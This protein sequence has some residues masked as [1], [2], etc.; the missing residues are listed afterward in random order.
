M[1]LQR[2]T[3]RPG[4]CTLQTV[5]RHAL[6]P[7]LGVLLV[8]SC[9]DGDSIDNDTA[10]DGGADDAQADATTDPELGVCGE[11]AEDCED[12]AS[13]RPF[14]LS[15]HGAA[16]L[17]ERRQMLVFG[18]TNA[19]AEACDFPAPD[20][21]AETW[22]FDDACGKWK[23]LEIEDGPS[24]RARHSMT[25]GNGLAWMFGGRWGKTGS[26]DGEYVVYAELWTFDPDSET[27]DELEPE[28]EAP[29]PRANSAMT[30]DSTRDV[31]WVWGGNIVVDGAFRSAND[32]WQY[33]PRG[34]RW[35]EAEADS[36]SPEARL[37]HSLVYDPRRDQ[38]VLYGGTDESFVPSEGV[39]GL[40]LESLRWS[41]LDRSGTSGPDLRYWQ[42]MVLDRTNDRL[43]MM[44]GHDN[45]DLGNRNDWW[46][47]EL[48]NGTWSLEGTGDRLNSSANG[49]CDFP[50]DFTAPDL[51][52]PER[53]HGHSMVWSESCGHTIVF[54]GKTDCGAT[55]DVW[56]LSDDG[57]FRRTS[58][59]EGEVCIRWREDPDDCSNLC[60]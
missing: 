6:P 57:W 8:A 33:D 48:E 32:L 43:V 24:P 27:W 21:H 20:Y 9:G 17:E 5:L 22:I 15:E 31:L 3:C 53:R 50:P 35:S 10:G 11:L 39:W 40:D 60:N 30:W 38:L 16:Y 13:D 46:F 19:I 28:G 41:R 2:A 26:T 45:T 7:V 36:L 25:Y 49:F 51:S 52:A 42:A 14:R 54:A 55:D 18:G 56:Q 59:T 37:Y 34:N 4:C 29:A 44:G 1:T 23:Q 12:F 47:F 58:A